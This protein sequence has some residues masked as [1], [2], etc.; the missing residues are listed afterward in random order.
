MAKKTKY[1]TFFAV[2]PDKQN[3]NEC[4]LFTEAASFI[5]VHT[6]QK[7]KFRYGL[8]QQYGVRIILSA[9]GKAVKAKSACADQCDYCPLVFLG[10]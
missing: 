6:V 7:V 3:R 2:R 10:V 8:T 1:F 4:S 5:I 9:Q